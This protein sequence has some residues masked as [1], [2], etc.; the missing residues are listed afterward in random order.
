[1]TETGVI[2]STGWENDKRV[3]GHVGYAL[4][5]TEIRLWNEELNQ[6]ITAFDTQGEIRVRGPSITTEYW[7]L[8]EATA[9]EFVDAGSSLVILVCG[10]QILQ[11][12]IN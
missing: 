1:M 12:R 8:P 9:K 2:A 3:K 10:L 6:A 4:P 7:R 11:L 5:G